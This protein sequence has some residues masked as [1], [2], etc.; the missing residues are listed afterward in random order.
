LTVHVHKRPSSGWIGG[1]FATEHINGGLLEEDG[2]LWE[3]SG[4]L[5]AVARQIAVI[6]RP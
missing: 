4:E 5:V 1:W 6:P 2:V 3:E